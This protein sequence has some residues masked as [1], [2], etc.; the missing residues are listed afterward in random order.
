MTKAQLENENKKLKERINKLETACRNFNMINCE[1]SDR[2]LEMKR[3]LEKAEDKIKK[4]EQINV[5]VEVK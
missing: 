1:L 4:Y 2:F 5:E 3:E